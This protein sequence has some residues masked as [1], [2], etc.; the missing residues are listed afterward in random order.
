[1]KKLLLVPALLAG[2]ASSPPPQ[3]VYANV[4]VPAVQIVVDPR[5][6]QMSR[7]EVISATQDCETNGMRA[8]PIMSKRLIS[9]MMSDIIVDV[10]CMPKPKFP[11]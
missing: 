6:Q 5:V 10:Q 9:G 7:Q 2:C 11:Y 3:H 1:M 4:N 8:V